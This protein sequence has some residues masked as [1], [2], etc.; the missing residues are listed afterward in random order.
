METKQLDYT[1]ADE[2]ARE[3]IKIV[4]GYLTSHTK[5]EI[6]KLIWETYIFGRE[7]HG[8]QIRKSGEPYITHPLSASILLTQIKPD[9]VSIQACILHDV[10]EDT[11]RTEA[12]IAEKFGDD[13]AKICQ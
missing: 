13:V 6:E 7:A 1:R 12:E 5:E 4:Q 10:I 3:L 2:L 8:D 9:I 11:P